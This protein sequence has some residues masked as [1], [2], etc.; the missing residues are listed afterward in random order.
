MKNMKNLGRILLSVAVLLC[1][2]G[3]AWGAEEPIRI[4]YLAAITGDGSVWGQA[5]RAGAT[6]CVKNI[7]ERGGILGRPVEL[8]CYDTKGKPEDA[9]NAVRRMIFEDK[10]VA[11]GGSNYSSIQ[12]A[13]ASIADKNQIPVVATAA[14][15]PAVT[16]DPDTGK[17]R[18]YMFRIA[19]TDPYQGKVIADYL[20]EKCGAKKIAVLG[21]IGDA[22]S[23]GLTEFIQ[24]RAE[25]LKV[26]HK[27]WAFRGGDV[28]FRAQLTEAKNWGAEAVAM[29]MLY[30]EMGLV[31]KQAVESGWKPYFMGGDGVSPNIFEI[32]GND[33][34]EGSFWIQAMSYTD[35]KVLELNE[36]YEK[37]FGEKATEPTNLVAAYDVVLFIENA[38]TRAGKAEG[39]AI[40]DAMEKTKGLKVTHFTWTVDEAT[41]NPLN[42]PAAVHRG[43]DGK[44]IFT[45][46]WAP[47]DATR[48]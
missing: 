20:V 45:E 48:Q 14:T 1:V 9:V 2:S 24:K 17:I 47:Q 19:Y 23:E 12:L 34:M 6:F 40:R 11:I 15:N 18:P 7:N 46:Y 10:V 4:G 38:I 33:A 39:P 28:D 29:T 22:Y 5:E 21:D 35:P 43:T 16:V 42:K 36:K 32:A 27:F 8:I 41:H 25:E 44:L 26:E 31:I 30:K 37:E 13:I 3:W